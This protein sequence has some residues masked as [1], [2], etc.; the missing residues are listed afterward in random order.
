MY[1][2]CLEQGLAHTHSNDSMNVNYCHLPKHGNKQREPICHIIYEAD[3]QDKS[4]SKVC[5]RFLLLTL[6]NSM[7]CV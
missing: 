3:L 2:K 1:V 6:I 5:P 7:L 4:M